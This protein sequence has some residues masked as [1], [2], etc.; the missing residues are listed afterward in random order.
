METL[1]PEQSKNAGLSQEDQQP[2]TPPQGDK[3]DAPDAVI[4]DAVNDKAD[5]AND[6]KESGMSGLKSKGGIR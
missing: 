3:G 4:D 5:S 6:V 1:N 2:A